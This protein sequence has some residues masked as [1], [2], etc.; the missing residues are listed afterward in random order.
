MLAPH[1]VARANTVVFIGA[2]FVPTGT[3]TRVT[4]PVWVKWYIWFYAGP[5]PAQSLTENLADNRMVECSIG[6]VAHLRTSFF[7]R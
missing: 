4:V 3:S 5:V 2:A 7:G 1:A 6:R